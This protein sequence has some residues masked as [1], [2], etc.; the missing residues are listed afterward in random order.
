MT[1]TSR[2]GQLASPAAMAR[3][4]TGGPPDDIR[5]D[6]TVSLISCAIVFGLFIDGWA[7]NHDKVDDS[8]FTPWH[9]L[10]YGAVALAGLALIF[11]HFRNVN[12]G[13]RWSQALPSGYALSLV[14]F[15][16]FGAG[17]LV[18]MIWHETFGFEEGIEALVSPSH[19]FL[20]LTGIL[21]ISGPI[22]AM[23]RRPAN[24]TWLQLMP[25]ILSS[26]C[27]MSIFTFFTSFTAVTPETILLVGPRPERHTLYDIA[28]IWSFVMHSSLLIGAVLFLT[29]RWHLPF[30]VFTL[31]FFLNSV[32][33]VWM[34][35]EHTEEFLF[36]ISA[37]AAG[38]LA[39]YLMSGN[40]PVDSRRLR[41]AAVLV[42]FTYSLGAM[43]I[44]QI[45]GTTVWSDTGLWWLIHMWLG[46][47]VM[48]GAFGYGLS[49]LLRPPGLPLE[50][51]PN[52]TVK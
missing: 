3:A 38:L 11:T 27:L 34:R 12:R 5:L 39:D 21:I 44:V 47:P 51:S 14:G 9:A 4:I 30:G 24:D 25:V 36:A 31:M 46:V 19:L 48:A 7:H 15:F 37:A 52:G 35:I 17:G 49:L 42:P 23:W 1:S 29:R 22:R 32:L 43:I 26:A 8:F 28:G 41:I 33:M 10:L 18:D 40:K 20:A 16:A 50:S 6:W 13:Y 45:L 2:A